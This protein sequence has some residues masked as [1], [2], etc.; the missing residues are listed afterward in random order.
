MG[1]RAAVRLSGILVVVASALAWSGSAG[2]ATVSLALHDPVPVYPEWRLSYEAA[3][4]EDNSLVLGQL[5][6]PLGPTGT[7]I[8]EERG[9]VPITTGAGCT[10]VDASM[11]V[12]SV[13]AGSTELFL[14]AVVDL[15]DVGDGAHALGACGPKVN[16]EEFDCGTTIDGG[17]GEDTIVGPQAG[18]THLE[19]GDGDDR[20]TA[21]GPEADDSA[22][23][24]MFDGGPGSDYLAG[25]NLYDRVSYADRAA[26]V[27]VTLDGRAN[28]GEAGEGDN[29]VDIRGVVTGS[30][31]DVVVGNSRANFISTG[32][33]RDSVRAGAGG[34][35]LDGGPGRDDL[36]G[37]TGKD[38][39]E[40]RDGSRESSGA[41]TGA[42]SPV[43]IETSTSSPRSS[44]S[45]CVADAGRAEARL[46][47]GIV[48]G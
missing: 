43:P 16:Q 9:G 36:R 37:S 29:V 35:S 13:P 10:S 26:D 38:G 7:W 5:Y 32:A 25:N 17:A 30:G 18:T 20:L 48:T 22:N 4:G 47:S 28:D 2:A 33:G 41:A 6:G 24:T 3:P 15:G 1:G 27:R 40:A 8:I 21:L 31:A 19:G 14:H 45:A 39:F 23:F 46:R 34:D 11:A 12:C 42:T 44:G